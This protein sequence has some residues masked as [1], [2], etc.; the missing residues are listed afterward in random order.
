MYEAVWPYVRSNLYPVRIRVCTHVT[1]SLLLAVFKVNAIEKGTVL[2]RVRST[3]TH[4]SCT[5]PS[6]KF[7]VSLTLRV[8]PVGEDHN[9]NV[10][11]H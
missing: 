4:I 7:T 9:P 6:V 11:I 5:S 1:D 3:T 2:S 10:C 8:A